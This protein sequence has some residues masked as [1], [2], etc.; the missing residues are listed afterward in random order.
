MVIEL[1]FIGA[2]LLCVVLLATGRPLNIT[3]K[4][5]HVVEDH[6]EPVYDPS[7]EEQRPTTDAT[8]KNLPEFIQDILGVTYDEE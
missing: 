6:S 5:I 2:L 3:L 8:K 7:L 4:H 1:I